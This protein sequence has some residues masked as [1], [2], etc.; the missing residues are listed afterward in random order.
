MLT[1]AMRP[2]MFTNSDAA[3][4][5]GCA[6]ATA[7]LMDKGVYIAMHGIVKLYNEI[8]RDMDTGKYY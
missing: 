6:I 1:G 8:Q 4:N 5:V 3:L 2:E 7:S